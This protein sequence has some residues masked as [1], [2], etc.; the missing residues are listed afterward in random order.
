[1]SEV[2]ARLSFVT[3]G[4]R[5]FARQRAFYLGLGWAPGIDVDDFVSFLVG[6]VVLAIYPLELLTAEAAPGMQANGEWSGVT[7]ACNVATRDEVD[8]AW[9]AWVAAGATP[10]AAPVDREYGPRAGYVAD[11]EGNRWEIA[12]ADGVEFDERGAV[13]K[14]GD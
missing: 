13:T 9:A 8:G 11:P 4:A 10:L 7:L 2:P 5:D 14:F 1:M 6:G 12:F 3:L